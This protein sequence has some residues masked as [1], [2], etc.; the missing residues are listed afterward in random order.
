[1]STPAKI[2]RIRIAINFSDGA[3]CKTK[4]V[5]QNQSMREILPQAYN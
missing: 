2:N 5:V 4:I 3:L 1:M